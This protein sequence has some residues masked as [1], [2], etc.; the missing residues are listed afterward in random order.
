MEHKLCHIP[1]ITVR[2]DD[3]LVS[4]RSDGEYLRTLEEV[5]KVLSNWGCC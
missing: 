2:V 3:I 1:F 5:L 4:G